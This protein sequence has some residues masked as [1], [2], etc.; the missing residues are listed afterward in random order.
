MDFNRTSS[1]KYKDGSLVKV[2]DV[3]T[4]GAVGREEVRLKNRVKVL[5]IDNF[6]CVVFPLNDYSCHFPMWSD[7]NYKPTIKDYKSRTWS[8]TY[9]KRVDI[10]ELTEEELLIYNSTDKY[11]FESE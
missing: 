9:P 3:I 6:C 11:L 5:Y 10:S 8:F 4:D 2:G 7:I 1:Y